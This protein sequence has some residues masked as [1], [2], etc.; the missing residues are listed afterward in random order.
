MEPRALQY[1]GSYVP[2][3]NEAAYGSTHYRKAQKTHLT[4][5]LGVPKKIPDA[6]QLAHL[7]SGSQKQEHPYKQQYLMLFEVHHQQL[8][9]K[10]VIKILNKTQDSGGLKLI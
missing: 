9:G 3:H 8:D 6:V 7:A 5:V 1:I 2:G 4:K 10:R